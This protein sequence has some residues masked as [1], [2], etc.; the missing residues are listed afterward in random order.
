MFVLKVLVKTFK[1]FTGWE[2][3]PPKEE[4][5]NGI[6]ILPV[7]TSAWDGLHAVVGSTEYGLTPITFLL[8]RFYDVAPSICSRLGFIRVPDMDSKSATA[9]VPL[10][11]ELRK[12]TKTAK[13]PFSVTICPEG[14]RQYVENFKSSFLYLS[15]SLKLPIY[16]LE[17][18]YRTKQS[19]VYPAID[20]RGLS[21]KQVMDKIRKYVKPE[22]GLYPE[23]AGNP[24]LEVEND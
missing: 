15:R 22:T 4:L 11:R 16:V 7:H 3:L 8:D 23:Q 2:Y 18:D 17:I 1:F 21:D 20:P 24:Y 5:K 12:K 14:N 9:F 19:Q 13:S 10:F 6:Y